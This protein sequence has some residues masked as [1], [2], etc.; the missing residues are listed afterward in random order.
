MPTPFMHLQIAEQVSARLRARPKEYGPLLALLEAEWPAF[1][2]G[3][4]APDFQSVCGIPREATHFYRL[5]PDPANLAYPRMLA[6]YP[7]L[8]DVNHMPSARVLFV[9]GY[10]AHLLLDLIWFR[11]IVVPMFYEPV[12]LG[13][14]AQ[15]RLLH[16]ILLAYLDRLALEALPDSAAATLT[17]AEPQAW[18]PFARD[19][20][21]RQWRDFLVP[22]L[23]P[24]APTR[25]IEIYAARLSMPAAAFAAK[26]EDGDWLRSRLF[27]QVPLQR[28]QKILRDAVPPTIQRVQNYC[29]GRLQL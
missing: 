21:L 13:D 23:Q 11:Q 7:E 29:E 19:A 20:D 9:A 10:I 22:Q 12:H 27:S 17:R 18:L 1:C 2:F 14:L 6:R 28:I 25:T 4:V 16:L 15:R 24:G 8:A 26:L 5:P 3:G